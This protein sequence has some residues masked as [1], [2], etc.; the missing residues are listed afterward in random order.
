MDESGSLEKLMD[1]HWHQE[2]AGRPNLGIWS[3]DR[4]YLVLVLRYWCL[5]RYWYWYWYWNPDFPRIGIGIG[6]D[7]QHLSGIGI[8]IG[9]EIGQLPGIGIG[10][11]PSVLQY[12]YLLYDTKLLSKANLQVSYLT[13]DAVFWLIYSYLKQWAS[14]CKSYIVKS[15]ESIGIGIEVLVFWPVLVLVLVLTL[16]QMKVLVLVLVLALS[17]SPVLV[18]VLVLTSA[19]FWYWYWYWGTKIGIAGLWSRLKLKLLKKSSKNAE[20]THEN[21]SKIEFFDNLFPQVFFQR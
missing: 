21:S 16:S 9:I 18:L 8:G 2:A 12:Q 6:I 20:K 11:D 4:Q 13:N 7:H 19:K 5:G 14:V 15:M 10:I 3:R 17:Q 1:G